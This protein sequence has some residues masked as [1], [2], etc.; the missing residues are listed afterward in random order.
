MTLELVRTII[1]THKGKKTFLRSLENN[2]K[3]NQPTRD[4]EVLVRDF[5]NNCTFNF[6]FSLD[7]SQKSDCCMHL[8]DITNYES[9]HNVKTYNRHEF[10]YIIG[11]KLD[12]SLQRAV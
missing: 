6:K 12:M 8:Y 3:E 5:K 11:N 2:N 9:F 10:T 7:L 4:V 1:I